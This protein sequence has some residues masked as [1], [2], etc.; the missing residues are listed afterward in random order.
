MISKMREMFIK[1]KLYIFIF[2]VVFFVTAPLI[3]NVFDFTK[4]PPKGWVNHSFGGEIQEIISLPDTSIEIIVKDKPGRTMTFRVSSSTKITKEEEV[5][6]YYDLAKGQKVLVRTKEQ[7][8]K[9]EEEVLQA[10]SIQFL[11]I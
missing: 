5:I 6:A 3:K 2:L 7:I 10:K 9:G 11:S 4:G 1:K 8:R